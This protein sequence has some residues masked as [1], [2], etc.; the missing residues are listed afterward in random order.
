MDNETIELLDELENERYYLYQKY[1]ND[2]ATKDIKRIDEITLH[3]M[4][5]KNT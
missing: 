5:I 3:I 2:K 1:Y 4:E